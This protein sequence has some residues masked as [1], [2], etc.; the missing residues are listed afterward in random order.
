[1]LGALLN[2]AVASAYSGYYYRA[3]DHS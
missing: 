1:M 2:G 3:A